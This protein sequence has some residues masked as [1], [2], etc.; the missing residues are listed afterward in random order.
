MASAVFSH[1]R[2]LAQYCVDA[3]TKALELSTGR[4]LRRLEEEEQQQLIIQH[5]QRQQQQQQQQLVGDDE[6]DVSSYYDLTFLTMYPTSSSLSSSSTRPIYM[7]LLHGPGHI[8]RNVQLI[9][10]NC[11]PISVTIEIVESTCDLSVATIYATSIIS[12]TIVGNVLHTILDTILYTCDVVS[13][14]NPLCI[15][16]AILSAKR[17]AVGKTGD[18][19]VSGIQSVATGVGS[20]SNAALNRL[21][22]SGL[23]VLAGG[24]AIMMGGSSRSARGS[25]SGRDGMERSVT[26][27]N[28][29]KKVS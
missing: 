14:F 17:H 15:V 10:L 4:R 27:T 28:M 19:L 3:Y 9:I 29:E 1:P 20:V 25:R 23:A 12:T 13:Q 26:P 21:S 11:T 6:D 18:V 22:R 2:P 24:E 8:I 16:D 7:I 5:Q